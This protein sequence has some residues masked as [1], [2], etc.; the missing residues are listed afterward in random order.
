VIDATRFYIDGEWVDP[1]EP[2]T[3]EVVNPATEAPVGRISLAGRTDVDRAVAAA[4]RA[5]DSYSRTSR[6]ERIAL[7]EKLVEAYRRRRADMAEAIRLEMGAP[8]ALAEGAQSGAGL[9]HLVT[10]L[11]VLREFEFEEDLGTTRVFR[12][13]IGVCALIT[14]WNWPMNQVMCKV[15]PALATGCTIVLKPSQAAPF[16]SYVLA[17]MIDEAGFPSG[18]FNMV[19]GAGREVGEWLS[20]HPDIDMISLTGSNRAGVEVARLAAPT[21]KRVGLELGGK[22]AN[23]ILEDADL[24]RAVEHGV[25]ACMNNT[26][27]SCN[28]PTR[29]LVP[30]HLHEEAVEIARTVAEKIRVGSPEDPTTE[31]GPQANERQWRSVQ[32]L[33][34]A[35]IEDGNRIVCGGPGRPEGLEVGFYSR[36]TIF[37]DVRNEDRIARE[38]VFG[39]VLVIIPYRDEVDAVRIANDSIYGLSGYVSSGEPER[40]RRVA[41]R[42]RTGSVHLNGAGKDLKAPFGGYKQSGNGREWGVHGFDEFLEIKSVLGFTSGA[43][44]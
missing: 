15:A 28:A 5:F 20:T 8:V 34:Q 26:G 14:P 32:K 38:E 27:Q 24:P 1:S 7:L 39:P 12:E 22:S 4:R 25:R 44:S 29:M 41:S 19:N 33:I 6:E 37:A 42:M 23:I 36:P 16:D 35:A 40:A 18:V 21:V 3:A 30:E 13:P 2:R 10:A 11:D 17:E 31:V 9:G 43:T